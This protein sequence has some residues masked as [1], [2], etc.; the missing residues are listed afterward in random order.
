MSG[1]EAFSKG[2]AGGPRR[3]TGVMAILLMLVPLLHGGGDNWRSV[4]Q[5]DKS[6][7]QLA[8]RG[9]SPASKIGRPEELA[10]LSVKDGCPGAWKLSADHFPLSTSSSCR[11][12][13]LSL[14]LRGLRGCR[15]C[16]CSSGQSC[17]AEAVLFEDRAD[18]VAC[19]SADPSEGSHPTAATAAQTR[20]THHGW[21]LFTAAQAVGSSGNEGAHSGLQQLRNDS[22][23]HHNHDTRTEYS[24]DTETR[25]SLDSPTSSGYIP[26][27]KG[28]T[29]S[30]EIRR[31]AASVGLKR[32]EKTATRMGGSLPQG[33]AQSEARGDQGDLDVHRPALHQ[34]QGPQSPSLRNRAV[35]I[36]EAAVNGYS[37]NTSV[38][39][40]A[41]IVK[42]GTGEVDES[43]ADNVYFVELPKEPR[44]SRAVAD[45]SAEGQVFAARADKGTASP[46]SYRIQLCFAVAD[47]QRRAPSSEVRRDARTM[48]WRDTESST[49]RNAAS[50]CSLLKESNGVLLA[51]H[52]GS[53]L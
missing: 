51:S 39:V 26:A 11:V 21:Y 36:R 23:A 45:S 4:P 29:E 38:T 7:L 6:Q 8:A 24:L 33:D 28:E 10:S 50:S 35:R 13:H 3:L 25:N 27:S 9:S 43:F 16:I 31:L 49:L 2:G 37:T 22:S 53:K 17:I 12:R 34:R 44:P 32:R 42:K 40:T 1:M 47:Q 46:S 14:P 48:V 52:T 18:S 15:R 19:S 5:R 30:D 41:E 20:Q